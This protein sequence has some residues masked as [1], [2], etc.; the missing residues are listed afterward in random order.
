M[1]TKDVLNSIALEWH[2]YD[3]EKRKEFARLY[4]G[5]YLKLSDE[6]LDMSASEGETDELQQ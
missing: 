5:K 2:T 4:A 1:M 6:L 3:D